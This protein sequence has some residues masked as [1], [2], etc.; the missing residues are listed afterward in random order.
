M[1]I[2][3]QFKNYQITNYK[4]GTTTLCTLGAVVTQCEDVH[5]MLGVAPGTEQAPRHSGYIIINHVNTDIGVLPKIQEGG[6]LLMRERLVL[7]F[8]SC[9]PAGQQCHRRAWLGLVTLPSPSK[10]QSPW[11]PHQLRPGL[12]FPAG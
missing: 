5:K 12:L 1:W 3:L 9:S 8:L 6:M 11:Q 4:T 10:E 2:T 7:S